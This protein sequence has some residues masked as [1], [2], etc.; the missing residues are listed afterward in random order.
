MQP[1][2]D[3]YKLRYQWNNQFTTYIQARSVWLHGHPQ[4]STRIQKSSIWYEPVRT[5]VMGFAQ[6][7]P[8][9]FIPKFSYKRYVI[10][11][12]HENL[13]CL[14]Y[15]LWRA[16][17]PPYKMSLIETSPMFFLMSEGLPSCNTSSSRVVVTAIHLQDGW[18]EEL[19]K[20][21]IFFW[22]VQQGSPPL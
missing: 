11:R 16:L 19:F 4:V 20:W 14:N 8:K 13:F 9:F 21:I 17:E 2:E 18:P 6:E 3:V 5:N 12:N 7:D 15:I 1:T 22:T 10:G